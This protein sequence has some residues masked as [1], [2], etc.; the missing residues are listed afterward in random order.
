MQNYIY[1]VKLNSW[2]RIR[3]ESARIFSEARYELESAPGRTAVALRFYTQRVQNAA[4]CRLQAECFNDALGL[5]YM[6]HQPTERVQ[7]PHLIKILYL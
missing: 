6:E 3:V 1:S 4:G 5:K 7:A 2:S